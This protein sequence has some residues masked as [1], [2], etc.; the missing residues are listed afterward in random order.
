M[1]LS[2]LI[3]PAEPVGTGTEPHGFIPTRMPFGLLMPHQH[4]RYAC[5]AYDHT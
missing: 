2:F 5:Y 3:G 1:V 4:G